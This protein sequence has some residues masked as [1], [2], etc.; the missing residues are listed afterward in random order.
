MTDTMGTGSVRVISK[1]PLRYSSAK[2]R[3]V[4]AG[5]TNARISGNSEKK[6]RRSARSFRKNGEK[7]NQPMTTRKTAMTI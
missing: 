7:K 3:M 5:T 2:I 4:I 6:S 1:V